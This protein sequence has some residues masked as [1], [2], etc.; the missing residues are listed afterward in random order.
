MKKKSESKETKEISIYMRYWNYILY[1]L[2]IVLLIFSGIYGYLRY[3]NKKA[4]EKYNTAFDLF[5]KNLHKGPSD[6][7]LQ[8]SLSK[9]EEVIKKYSLSQFSLLSMPFAGYICFIKG[10]YKDAE[11]YYKMFKKKVSNS[12]YIFLSDLALSSCYESENK[13]DNAIQILRS[14]SKQYPESPFKEFAL[15]NLERLYR[16]EGKLDQSKK[17]IKQ[18][19][20]RYPQSPFFYMAKSH[21]LSYNKAN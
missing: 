7:E 17:I 19:L 12:E 1:P 15:L 13:L 9:F 3:V 21:F 14:V 2:L 6:K 20:E 4:E 8:K 10:D 16:M 18:F 11:R 5:S